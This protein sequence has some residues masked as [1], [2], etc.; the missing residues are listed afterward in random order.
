MAV[1]HTLKCVTMGMPALI[2]GGHPLCRAGDE[3]LAMR[4]IG[5]AELIQIKSDAFGSGE[6]IP[7]QYTADGQNVSPPI[8]WHRIAGGIESFALLVEDPDAPTPNPFVHWLAYNIPGWA[9]GIPE[10]IAHDP[11][12]EQPHMLQ[13]KNSARKIGYT[14]CAP[15]KGD[16]PHHYHFQLFAL[17]RILGLEPGAGRSDLMKAMKGHVVAAGDLIG[18]YQRA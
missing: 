11:Q 7:T 14:G 3:R 5:Q 13:G 18:T 4:N 17:D 8:S 9:T 16:S 15:P 2:F 6:S 12:L 1:L 10:A